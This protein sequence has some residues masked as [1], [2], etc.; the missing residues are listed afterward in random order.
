MRK[1]FASFACKFPHQ[2]VGCPYD[3]H[4][5]QIIFSNNISALTYLKAVL[6]KRSDLLLF[7]FPLWKR[8]VLV[9]APAPVPDPDSF[10]KTTKLHKI[11]S[12]PDVRKQLI[13]R[14]WPLIF[15]F[16]TFLLQFMSAPDLNPVPEPE[17]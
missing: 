6:W 8:L 3:F 9:T 16:L 14:T 7:R 12:F 13:P 11:L 2:Q 1:K 17:P 4:F 15:D 10:P 5:R